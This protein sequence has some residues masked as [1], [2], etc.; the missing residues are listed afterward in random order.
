MRLTINRGLAP[1]WA[2][3]LVLFFFLPTNGGAIPAFSRQYQTSCSTCHID[4]PKLNDSEKRL[5][6]RALSFPRTTRHT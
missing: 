6:T 5:R 2:L 1:A 4:F 3:L